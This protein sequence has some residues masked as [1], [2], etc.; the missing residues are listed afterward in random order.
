MA[1]TATV[2]GVSGRNLEESIR[3]VLAD[4]HARLERLFI[5]LID[6]AQTGE[7]AGLRSAWQASEMALLA[8]MDAE[9]RH[10]VGAFGRQE[11]AEAEALLGE[12]EQIRAKLN[13]M[14]IAL[15]LHSL[16]SE[17]L[18]AFVAELRA[19]ARR[20]EALLYPWAARHLGEV[21]RTRVEKA[22]ASA[23][24]SEASEVGST[25]WQIDPTRSTLGF[26]LRH[27]VVHHIR[28]TFRSWGGT[29]SLDPADP[30]R[31]RVDVW[32]DLT[33]IDTGDPERDDHVRSAEFFEVAR[34]PRAVFTSRSVGLVEGRAPVIRGVLGLHGVMV[35]VPVEITANEKR[36]DPAGGERRVYTIKA[37][38]DRQQFGLRWNQDL[39]AGGVVVGDN[40]AVEA[41]VETVQI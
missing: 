38:L 37:S 32:V 17:R 3:T 14:A 7:Q 18:V 36:V 4:D 19:H 16:R 34:H 22:L 21:A 9:E 31:S 15:D 2:D 23:R 1:G 29:V 41:H 12:H 13:E 26:S 39:D 25:R 20:E 8:H 28:G 5:A 33:S 30:A 40:I 35:E 10:V 24:S 6:E 11:P 27:I